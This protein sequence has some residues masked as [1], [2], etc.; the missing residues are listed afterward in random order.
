MKKK[1]VIAY[2]ISFLCITVTILM[3]Y[4]LGFDMYKEFNSPNGKYVLRV[5]RN[6]RCQVFPGNS[7]DV[8]GF[9]ILKSNEDKKCIFCG[10]ID[11]IQSIDEV[12]WNIDSVNINRLDGIYFTGETFGDWGGLMDSKS[13]L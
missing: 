12:V 8:S 9:I 2:I 3:Y 4:V 7:G 1:R 11:M 6:S 13:S 5:Y 10:R